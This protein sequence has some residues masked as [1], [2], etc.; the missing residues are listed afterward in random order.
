[1]ISAP[2][3]T[4]ANSAYLGNTPFE[5][6]KS[7]QA[8][9]QTDQHDALQ[10]VLY[11]I[12]RKTVVTCAICHSHW[13]SGTRHN[14]QPKQNT[15]QGEDAGLDE[16]SQN[17]DETQN[18]WGW[19]K[20]HSVGAQA[21]LGV[22]VATTWQPGMTLGSQRRQS[23]TRQQK[24]PTRIGAIWRWWCYGVFSTHC[25]E[26]VRTG[27]AGLVLSN[28]LHVARSK[29]DGADAYETSPYP[30]AACTGQLT[31]F[32]HDCFLHWQHS[33]LTSP[34][35]HNPFA[36][37]L[38]AWDLRWNVLCDQFCTHLSDL[39]GDLANAPDEHSLHPSQ[40]SSLHFLRCAS[41]RHASDVAAQHTHMVQSSV[42][43]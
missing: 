10:P 43:A 37:V 7:Y 39:R 3:C 31:D 22:E 15:H 23:G 41:D 14:T 27:G 34:K 5:G 32:D 29:A 4:Q 24:A 30:H 13:S 18:A 26:A 42:V 16:W 8:H 19:E 25:S 11:R 36:A 35:Y 17:W 2:F 20:Q 40:D 28:S 38:S 9:L 6:Q 33:I 1:M 12:N 21:S